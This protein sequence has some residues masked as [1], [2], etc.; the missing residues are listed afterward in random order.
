[1]NDYSKYIKSAYGFIRS[2]KVKNGKIQIITPRNKKSQPFEYDVT[3][4]NVSEFDERLGAQQQL[5]ITHKEEIKKDI[6]KNARKGIYSLSLIFFIVASVTLMMG[7][8]IDINNAVF[9]ILGAL[10]PLTI[11]VG[12]TSLAIWKQHF[13]KES[14]VKA[15]YMVI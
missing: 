5:L 4:E 11:A 15:K 3:P 1:M 12:E 10:S 6:S 9:Y 8:I 7:N 14:K 13:D 2:Y